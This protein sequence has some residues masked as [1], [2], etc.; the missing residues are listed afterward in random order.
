MSK[1]VLVVDDEMILN[2]T[3]TKLLSENGY[4]PEA[5]TSGQ[6]CLDKLE[7]GYT[8]DIILMDIDLGKGKMDGTETT[9][10]IYRR[11]DIPV[12]LHSAH[13]DRATLEK[14]KEMTKYG[15][16]HKTPG[17]TEFL[18]ATL[19]M[20]MHL[21]STEKKLRQSEQ[22]FGDVFDSIEDGICVLD[23]D[24]TVIR[25]NNV[26]EEWYTGPLPLGGKKCHNAFHSRKEPCPDCPSL[27]VIESG[28]AQRH[29]DVHVA[30]LDVG[31]AEI[32]C[33]PIRESGT[34]K[35]IGVVEF[36]RDITKQK[37]AEEALRAS[38]EQYRNLSSHLQKVREEQNAHLAREIHDDFGQSLTAL[39]MNMSILQQDVQAIGGSR[40]VGE[41]ETTIRDINKILDETVGKTR[42]LTQELRPSVLD[43]EGIIESLG[44]QVKEFEKRFGISA[45]FSTNIEE[46][47]FDDGRSLAV[48][49][50]VQEALT[51][52]ARHSGA[53]HVDVQITGMED[54]MRIEVQDNG[55]G[56]AYPFLEDVDSFGILGMRERADFI[57]GDLTI[58]SSEGK[59]TKVVLQ[60]PIPEAS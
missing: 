2:M 21:H 58:E 41:L 47:Q 7:G 12:V 23:M 33:Y 1:K 52:T 6:Q 27:R 48:F 8:P 5:V 40:G 56:F 25:V 38:E 35:V 39:K 37:V 9:G 31:W 46:F 30:K 19:E 44:W 42:K 16:V 50:I 22:F 28:N 17:N 49:R 60:F 4:T 10:R 36:F 59:G 14:T 43:T 20:A 45:N 13:T 3:S 54:M 55:S 15:Y 53:T 29:A 57:D 24:L 51:N 34:E 18:L 32:Y 26:M 11:F